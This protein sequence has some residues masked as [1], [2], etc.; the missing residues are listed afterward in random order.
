MLEWITVWG[1]PTGA[2]RA[3]LF[4]DFLLLLL[5]VLVAIVGGHLFIWRRS[6]WQARDFILTVV[7]VLNLYVAIVICIWVL[8]QVQDIKDTYKCAVI[9]SMGDNCMAKGE[10]YGLTC[11]KSNLNLFDQG[12]GVNINRTYQ[13]PIVSP[14]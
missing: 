6:F 2:Q 7:E 4:F 13:P 11:Q 9:G 12:S 8:M 10:G 1:D 5:A 14:E 3:S